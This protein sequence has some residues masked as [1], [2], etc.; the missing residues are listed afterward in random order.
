MGP[1][2]R[3]RAPSGRRV[4]RLRWPH[5]GIQ[6]PACRARST[7]FS[8]Q[9]VRFLRAIACHNERA[10]FHAHK[11]DDEAHVRDPLQRLV[12]DLQPDLAEVS[13]HCRADPRTCAS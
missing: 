1:R 11:Q 9:T 10:W 7:Y 12:T 8:E 4:H 13:L 6:Q 5:Q 3:R 2:T